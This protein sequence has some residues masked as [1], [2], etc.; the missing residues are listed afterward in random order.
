M[1]APDVLARAGTCRQ[2]SG[3]SHS[4][5]V[6]PSTASNRNRMD[7]EAIDSGSVGINSEIDFFVCI[8]A[9]GSRPRVHSKHVHNARTLALDKGGI[10]ALQYL[11][12][13]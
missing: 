11:T 4:I 10:F 5:Y 2:C 1:V 8:C 9:D 7:P 6:G 3:L 12:K 13:C